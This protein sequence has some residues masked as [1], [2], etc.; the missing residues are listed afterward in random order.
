MKRIGVIAISAAVG[1]MVVSSVHPLR[2]QSGTVFVQLNQALMSV[3]PE[4]EFDLLAN[5]AGH[6][7]AVKPQEFDPGKTNLVQAAWLNAIGCPTGAF[8]AVPNATFTGVGGTEPFTDAACPTGDPNDQHNEGLLLVKTGPTRN[9]ASAV[10]ELINVKGITLT[11]LGYDIRKWGVSAS[12]LGSH[13]GAGAPRFNVVTIDG[14]VHFLGCNS[15]P[16]ETQAASP[17]GWLRLRWGV[18]GLAAAFP[19]ITSADVVTRIVIVF[20]E[21]QDTPGGPDQFGA[22]ILDNIDVN[23]VLVGHGA[24]DAGS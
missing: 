8:I 6:F 22:A 2:G 5:P 10:A 1:V 12:P 20:D 7:K 11:E 24:V 13:C 16:A 15:P 14:A 3:L 18:A 4:P 21:G 9:F 19:P 23:G 17:T